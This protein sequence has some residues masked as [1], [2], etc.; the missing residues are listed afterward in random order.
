[1]TKVISYP[2]FGVECFINEIKLT[3]MFY[4]GKRT[5]H[6]WFFRFRSME[7]ILEA[8]ERNVTNIRS[9]EEDKKKRSEL[10]KAIVASDHFVLGDIIVNSWGFD[11]TNI[12][13]YQVVQV[14][15]KSIRVREIRQIYQST[16]HDCGYTMPKIGSFIESDDPFILSLKHSGKS[17]F[18]CNPKS[19]YYF[20]KWDGTKEYT[21][22]YA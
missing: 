16:G 22:S 21:S 17:V 13:F 5:K 6:D 14:L 9:R 8:V 18:I 15:N 19:F 1:M 10:T 11:Q 20:H 4:S 2:E 12:E 3:A 7:E